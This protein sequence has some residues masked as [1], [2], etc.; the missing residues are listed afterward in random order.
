MPFLALPT[1]LTLY[2][3]G[4]LDALSLV[5]CRSVCREVKGFIDETAA[6]Q[7]KIALFASG[8][9][10]GPP[11]PLSAHERLELLRQYEM[12]WRGV[13]WNE[14]TVVPVPEGSLW[15]LYGN[16]WAH[17]R[18]EDAIELVQIP[19]RLRGIPLR[20][21]T[22]NLDFS[23]RDFGMDPSQD[24]LVAVERTTGDAP[25][26]CRIRLCTLSTGKGHP[27]AA[28]AATL[29]Y[30]R[31]ASENPQGL[32]SYSIRISGNYVGV[33]FLDHHDD[34]ND[35]VVWDWTTGDIMMELTAIAISAFSFLGEHFIL[36]ATLVEP[37]PET[38]RPALLVYD[39]NQKPALHGA[40][41]FR[42]WFGV[43]SSGENSEMEFTLAMDPSPGW[44]P[45]LDL[46][47]PFQTA[48]ND[49]TIALN[50]SWPRRFRSKTFLMPTNALLKS[51]S[52]STAVEEG[53]DI[54]WGAW[55]QQ[56]VEHF[57]AHG[58]W[59]AYTCFV[60]G[61][62]YVLPQVATWRSKSAMLVRDFSLTRYRRT[63]QDE[64]QESE[65]LYPQLGMGEPYPRS[66]VKCVLLPAGIKGASRAHLMVSEDGI[67]ALEHDWL[68][69]GRRSLHLLTI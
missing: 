63:G 55:G 8:M 67:V 58:Q 20:R 17:S 25:R 64:R 26:L 57:P 22:L 12:S 65:K 4:D 7:Y 50:L 42:F 27:L 41:A 51:I 34:D 3:L 60:Y 28:K 11:G 33:L 62:R 9:E 45:S 52:E 29:E 46:Q 38:T 61:M 21:W 36:G 30:S 44:R 53:R 59:S 54:E 18:D 37:D 35:L 19:S 1:E 40:Y 10:D 5:K 68:V 31:A 23:L 24:L 69:G 13:Q 16:V 66:T 47:V 32:W 2:I 15:E 43:P 48:S 6:L 49:R 14:H 39:L 56:C